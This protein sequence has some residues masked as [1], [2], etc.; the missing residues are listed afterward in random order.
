MVETKRC[1]K[2]GL[3]KPE[4]EWS[5]SMWRRKARECGRIANKKWRNENRDKYKAMKR[6]WEK[7]NPEKVAT[8]RARAYRTNFVSLSE[9]QRAR[10]QKNREQ[11]RA[12]V[13]E[14]KFGISQA[15]YDALFLAQGGVCAICERP[16]ADHAAG[17]RLAVDH[18]H[19]TDEVRG[20]LCSS[21]NWGLAAYDDDPARFEAAARYLRKSQTQRVLAGS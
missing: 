15:G 17:R 3:D 20:L 19:E 6:R 7:A 9:K 11:I 18:D 5:P 21:C 12:R 14:R 10:Y 2:C 1:T 8:M 16:Q 4:S 13:L